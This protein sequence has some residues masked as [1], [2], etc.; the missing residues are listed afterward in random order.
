MPQVPGTAS[1]GA[2][3]Q[4]PEVKELEKPLPLGL[5]R[6]GLQEKLLL[7][8][9]QVQPHRQRV[10]ERH[11]VQ[12]EVEY[13]LKRLHLP[14]PL[15]IAPRGV[16]QLP[17]QAVRKRRD[18][19]LVHHVG[20]DPGLPV[21]SIE[22][23]LADREALR[24]QAVGDVRVV[25]LRADAETQARIEH[26]ADKCTEGTLSVPEPSL[27]RTIPMTRSPAM[28]SLTISR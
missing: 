16:H 22:P 8:H 28:Q 17:R 24:Q 25:E 13:L 27:R 2:L 7:D 26:L 14:G 19:V 23:F 5:Q 10:E 15:E 3:F 11:A 20:L 9:G 12:V 21:R 6:S 4:A 18:R 1:A